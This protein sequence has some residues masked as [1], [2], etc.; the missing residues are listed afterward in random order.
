[1]FLRIRQDFQWMVAKRQ[2]VCGTNI[3]K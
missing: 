1:V 3:A 2:S